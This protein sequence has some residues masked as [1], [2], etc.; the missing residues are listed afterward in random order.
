MDYYTLLLS[1]LFPFSTG[2]SKIIARNDQLAA[3]HSNVN[4]LETQQIHVN[5][6]IYINTINGGARWAE[7]GSVK[8]PSEKITLCI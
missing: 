1:S 5:L 6:L 7:R 3:L 4:P 8:P 2:P